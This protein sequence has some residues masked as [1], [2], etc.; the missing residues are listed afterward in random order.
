MGFCTPGINICTALEFR[1]AH[2]DVVW[3][4]FPGK[5]VIFRYFE[6]EH[7][8]DGS[9]SVNTLYLLSIRLYQK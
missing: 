3:R 2:Q 7:Q 8:E 9:K 6:T 1:C 5:I 4:Y